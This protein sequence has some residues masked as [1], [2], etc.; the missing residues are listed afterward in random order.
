MDFETPPLPF[1]SYPG[2]LPPFLQIPCLCPFPLP[3]GLLSVTLVAVSRDNSDLYCCGMGLLGLPSS[4]T[5]ALPQRAS[6]GLAEK[7][8]QVPKL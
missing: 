2:L 5:Q 7:V 3:L 1:P 6:E 8:N 4:Q